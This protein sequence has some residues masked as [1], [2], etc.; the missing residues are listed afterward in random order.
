MAFFALLAVV[1][2]ATVSTNVAANTVSPSYDFSNIAPR[3]VTFRIGGVITGV[4][5]ILMQPWRLLS[6]PHVYIFTWLGF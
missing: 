4:I 5:A 6:N 3:V 2:V 1:M